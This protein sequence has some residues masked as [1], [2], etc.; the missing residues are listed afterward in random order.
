MKE[1]RIEMLSDCMK[2]I[3]EVQD[4]YKSALE[5]WVLLQAAHGHIMSLHHLETETNFDKETLTNFDKETL[6]VKE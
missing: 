4:F 2:A 6:G 3:K 1:K 5:G